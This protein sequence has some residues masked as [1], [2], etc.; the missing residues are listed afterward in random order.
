MPRQP[1]PRLKDTNNDNTIIQHRRAANRSGMSISIWANSFS[2]P[3]GAYVRQKVITLTNHYIIT[4]AYYAI[5]HFCVVEATIIWDFATK[6][7]FRRLFARISRTPSKLPPHQ[8]ALKDPF[9]LQ[10]EQ[11]CNWRNS[12]VEDLTTEI[13]LHSLAETAA[14]LLLHFWLRSFH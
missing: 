11:I 8:A 1:N 4:L 3:A 7:I 2:V 13:K 6:L 10:A 12:V 9:Y 14:I 5:C